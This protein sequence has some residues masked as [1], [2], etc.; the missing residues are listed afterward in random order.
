MIKCDGVWFAELKGAAQRRRPLLTNLLLI[1]SQFNNSMACLQL[2]RFCQ[3]H[4]FFICLDDE[5]ETEVLQP[6]IDWVYKIFQSH[7]RV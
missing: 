4:Q 5:K 2:H 6:F 3:M 7:G 1:T